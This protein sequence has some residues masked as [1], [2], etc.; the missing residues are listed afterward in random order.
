MRTLKPGDQLPEWSLPM[1]P[2]TIVSTAGSDRAWSRR[3]TSPAEV[4]IEIAMAFRR[5]IRS[6]SKPPEN[7]ASI[8]PIP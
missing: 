6:V 8:A 2:T 5:P 4:I 3:R 1:T 7:C